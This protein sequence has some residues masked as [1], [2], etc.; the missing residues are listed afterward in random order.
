MSEGV[1][2]NIMKDF[3]DN[4]NDDDTI[5]FHP[6]LLSRASRNIPAKSKASG[7][8]GATFPTGETGR[9]QTI[10]FESLL[11]MKVLG[12][13]LAHPAT[14]DVREQPPGFFYTDPTGK[15]RT[16]TPDFMWVWKDGTRIC[17]EVKPHAK[18]VDPKLQQRLSCIRAAL[19]KD[20]ADRMILI[21][22]AD[23]TR[24]HALNAQRLLMFKPHIAPEHARRVDEVLPTLPYPVTIAQ[25]V[26]ELDIG[27]AGFQ[28]LFPAL[29]D[30]RLAVDPSAE[31]TFETRLHRGAAL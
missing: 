18:A 7:R 3:D 11:E 24:D 15:R 16:Y 26:A 28:A 19:R 21:T 20:M 9:I 29:F 30:G 25:A 2:T 27:S 17:V 31:F 23:F 6:A 13:L 5:V 1:L 14:L 10:A 4:N 12:I 8:G 22:D